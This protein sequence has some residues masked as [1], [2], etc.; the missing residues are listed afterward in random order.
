MLRCV[1]KG[2]VRG[3]RGSS[4]LQKTQN[5]N[6]LLYVAALGVCQNC[7]HPGI[8]NPA[9]AGDI[10]HDKDEEKYRRQY[11]FV[12]ART[13]EHY[14]FYLTFFSSWFMMYT[15]TQKLH[16]LLKYN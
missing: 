6:T 8:E 15:R 11:I 9:Y 3:D 16:K 2:S 10:S 5:R 7:S 4:G 1:S 14:Q 13:K 12:F